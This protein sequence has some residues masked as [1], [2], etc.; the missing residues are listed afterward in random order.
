MY[1]QNSDYDTIYEFVRA[2][3][4]ICRPNVGFMCQL[5]AWRKRVT[6]GSSRPYCFY[7]IGPHN[8]R[9]PSLVTK[10]VDRI[11]VSSLDS[12][13]LFMLQVNAPENSPTNAA[14]AAAAAASAQTI[15]AAAQPASHHLT[16]PISSPSS[17]SSPNS[18]IFIWVGSLCPKQNEK[19]YLPYLAHLIA[20]LQLYEHASERVVVIRQKGR[21]RLDR[22]ESARLGPSPKVKPAVDPTSPVAAS[23]SFSSELISATFHTLEAA[24]AILAAT[25]LSSL[26]PPA[27]AR[28]TSTF[29]KILGLEES[30]DYSRV[31][32][33]C[34]HPI[35]GAILIN[36]DLNDDYPDVPIPD[37]AVLNDAL[38]R[39]VPTSP[40]GPNKTWHVP[41]IVRVRRDNSNEASNGQEEDVPM[42]ESD[43]SIAARFN[44]TPRTSIN[45]GQDGLIL[46]LP[47][48]TNQD[49]E[50]SSSTS[51]CM[52]LP[53]KLFTSASPDSHTPSSMSTSPYKPK[54]SLGLTGIRNGGDDDDDES[55]M[56]ESSTIPI[57]SVMSPS[58][59][60][61]ITTP[62]ATTM[63]SPSPL[64]IDDASPHANISSSS[65][66]TP[67]SHGILLSPS[68]IRS[69]HSSQALSSP[70]ALFEFPRFDSGPI[71]DY[72]RSSLQPSNVYLLHHA[73]TN[74]LF[75]W[76]GP[77][78]ALFIP[79][80]YEGDREAFAE[81]IARIFQLATGATIQTMTIEQAG[82]ESESFWRGFNKQ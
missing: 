1:H 41:P 53:K 57:I 31:G 73:P 17:S 59:S 82:K 71:V 4:G 50:D 45:Q 75:V 8:G 81:D 28:E 34:S 19:Q 27:T 25:S 15:P 33:D 22:A 37:V 29:Y 6:K 77:P 74:S 39:S 68:S 79:S 16:S 67:S 43:E 76:M 66:A 55:T 10:W 70:Y 36:D 26:Y 48:R 23:P 47:S 60:P 5:L 64:R 12:R 3:R 44:R 24:P 40:S 13:T 56:D 52:T 2:R 38:W 61:I 11:E 42:D 69:P 78:G 65:Q 7:R 18:I 32:P 58:R 35:S 72:S 80:K 21:D 54:L 49:D 20:K 14:S 51:P 9:D 63:H 62:I 46:R 30:E